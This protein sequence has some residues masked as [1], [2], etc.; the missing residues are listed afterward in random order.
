MK[1]LT[2]S[3]LSASLCVVC[4]HSLPA[5]VR[6][7]EPGEVAPV[8]AAPVAKVAP[9]TRTA[10]VAPLQSV[11]SDKTPVAP[12]SGVTTGKV[13]VAP[14][15]GVVAGK[16]EMTPVAAAAPDASALKMPA[17]VAQLR[18]RALTPNAAWE[19]GALNVDDLLYFVGSLNHYGKFSNTEEDIELRRQMLGLLAKQGGALLGEPEKLSLA[20]R[21]WLA[22]YYWSVD[23]ERAITMAQSV[24]AQAKR[25]AV[26]EDAATF[27]ATESLAGYYE[28]KG[29]TDQSLAAWRQFLAL[30]PDEGWWT[31]H[32]KFRMAQT[33]SLAG[34]TAEAS[35]LYRQ[36]ARSADTMHAAGGVVLG[37]SSALRTDPQ[38]AEVQLL[39]LQKEVKVPDAR[40]ATQFLLAWA[41]YKAGDWDAFLRQSDQVLTHYETI[42]QQSRRQTFAALALQLEDGQKWAKLWQKSTIVAENPDLDLRFEG[43]LQQPVERRIFVDTPTPTL[44]QVT[45]EGDTNRVSAR[46]EESPWAP[47]L[48][49]VRHQQI[50]VVTIAPGAAQVE[51]KV[52]VI[53]DKQG[54]ELQIPV[55]ISAL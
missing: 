21:L 32:A 11:A 41:R 54:G 37:F 13:T 15:S 17:L 20:V 40:L 19:A 27:W 35:Q 55:R 25:P 48:E 52:R 5:S 29:Q 33:L 45:V 7:D 51:A 22:D 6:A 47:E 24:I 30:V 39:Q 14:L 26:G 42:E 43:P 8:K 28:D 9:Q 31:G 50:V 46:I 53:R 2:Q 4:L 16:A 18:A 44:L 34:R 36:I 49:E 3:A 1:T 10:P 38:T 12:L 23:D